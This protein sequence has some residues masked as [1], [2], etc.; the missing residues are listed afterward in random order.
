MQLAPP[1]CQLNH[2][3][4]QELGCALAGFQPGHPWRDSERRSGSSVMPHPWGASVSPRQRACGC[5]SAAGVPFQAGASSLVGSPPAHRPASRR[6]RN[7][8]AEAAES[9]NPF[10]GPA[11]EPRPVPLPWLSTRHNQCTARTEAGLTKTLGINS[12]PATIGRE[13]G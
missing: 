3:H 5:G 2:R 6:A 12:R 13:N 8:E 9:P 1:E 10:G 4:T 11:K 7:V